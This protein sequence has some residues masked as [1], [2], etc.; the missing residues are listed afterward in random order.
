[1][2]K[3]V[4]AARLWMLREYLQL[5]EELSHEVEISVARMRWVLAQINPRPDPFTRLAKTLQG[6]SPECI[7]QIITQA[8]NYL[9][10]A[11]AKERFFIVIDEAQAGVELNP[12]SFPSNATKGAKRPVLSIILHTARYIQGQLGAQT[13][14]LL[15]GTGIHYDSIK[16]VMESNMV[17]NV[18]IRT[19]TKTLQFGFEDQ[20]TYIARHLFPNRTS[21][22]QSDETFFNRAWRYLRGR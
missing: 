10:K 9:C 8:A 21:F 13:T 19:F 2:F 5:L 12:N 6:F 16:P 7:D 22:S 1:M 4:F 3:A 18:G 17:K 14:I 11:L 15:S 20:R